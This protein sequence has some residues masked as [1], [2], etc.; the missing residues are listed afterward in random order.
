M[1]KVTLLISL[2]WM[3]IIVLNGCG[4]KNTPVEK[5]IK[6]PVKLAPVVSE[7][8]K[9]PIHASGRLVTDKEQKLSFKI[10]G[11]IQKIAVDEGSAV[12]RGQRL[13]QLNLVEIEAAVAQAKSAV[14]KA[15]RDLERVRQLHADQVATLEQLQDATTGQTIARANLASAEFN[16]KHATIYAPGDGKI[17]KRLFSENEMVN[18]GMP[19]LVWGSTTGW[20]V[21]V[22]LAEQE[23][24]QLSHG[25]SANVSFDSYPNVVFPA[26]VSE[27]AEA[28]DP[29][30]GTFEV[31]LRLQPTRYRLLTG[32]VAHA[33]I[34]PAT[35]HP[36]FLIPIV[37]L[38]EGE[39]LRAAVFTV[40]DQLRARKISV[41]VAHLF[42]D[43]AGISSGLNQVSVVVTDG[44]AYL[45]DGSQVE[46]IGPENSNSIKKE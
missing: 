27:I 39:G 16:L 13:A 4:E 9:I 35:S 33:E 42:T 1:K 25:D 5:S 19:V 20:V 38:L 31:E 29:A 21:R 18:A 6:I 23:I 11:I 28:I 22:G 26:R 17:L 10:P 37:A 8:V 14:E 41:E 36:L 43:Q 12:A 2:C 46:I 24:V 34:L 7:P 15:T 40:D 32:F 45:S 3:V 44:A 30:S